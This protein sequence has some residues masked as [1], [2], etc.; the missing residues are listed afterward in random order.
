M[1]GIVPRVSQRIGIF[2]MVKRVIVDTSALLCL[3]YAFVLPILEYC[4]SV[5]GSA[6]KC[7]LQ[8]LD[9]QAYSVVRLC[10]DQTFCR[11]IDV[12]LL[13]CVCC[14]MLIRTLIIIELQ[15]S[16]SFLLLLL[17]FDILELRL[18]IIH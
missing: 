8:L 7:H 11:F 9:R 2:R 15:H 12:M 4:S 17:E 1:R 6:A 14:T 18:Q 3:Y 16:V 10:P 13:H 5:W